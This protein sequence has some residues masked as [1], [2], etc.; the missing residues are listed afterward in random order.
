MREKEFINWFWG[1]LFVCCK[2]MFA[3]LEVEEAMAAAGLPREVASG[4][5]GLYVNYE[6]WSFVIN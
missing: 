3:V 2:I 1:G 4:P 5:M 6:I